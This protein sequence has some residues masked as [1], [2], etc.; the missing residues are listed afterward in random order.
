MAQYEFR[1]KAC[2]ADHSVFTLDS[3]EVM[4][5][6]IL[7]KRIWCNKCGGDLRRV[8][9]FTST[10]SM[11]EHFNQ[12]LGQHVSS[13]RQLKD[14]FKVQSEL[15]TERT[16]IEHNFVPVHPSERDRLGVTSE[17]LAATY[18]R[19]KALGMAIPDVI[20]PEKMKD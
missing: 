20:R 6:G 19:R 13:E 8:F 7:H 10:K 16:G 3:K 17:G 15:A 1:C 18:D 2:N 14:A 12:S 11:P 5:Y 9:S 4:E